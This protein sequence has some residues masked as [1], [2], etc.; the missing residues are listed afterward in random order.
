MDS[1][2]RD[3]LIRNFKVLRQR[4]QTNKAFFKAR[5]YDKVI[6][7]LEEGVSN[8]DDIKGLG[9]SLRQKADEIMDKGFL[10]STKDAIQDTKKTDTIEE[11][12]KIMSIGNVKAQ[13][14]VNEHGIDSVESLRAK[15]AQEPSLLNDKQKMGLKY[16]DDF[17]K[18]IP[19]AEMDKH[20]DLLYDAIAEFT[21]LQ[22]TIT[23]SYRRG[24]ESSGDIDILITHPDDD[25]SLFT[26]LISAL[27]DRKYLVDDFAYGKE[28][29]MGVAKL[30]RHKTYRRID[31]MY[32]PHA[33]YPFALLYFTGSQEFNIEM[34]NHCLEM[35]YS[36]SEHGMKYMTGEE[37]GK[38]IPNV[39]QT[40]NDIFDFL[41][42]DYVEPQDRKKGAIHTKCS[43]CP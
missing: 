4:E 35:G 21:D 41:E 15:V 5:A 26:K 12:M 20:R 40:E 18:R 1:H 10:D 23:G 39:F 7:Q 24:V 27:K 25:K 33:M 31:V 6:K 38:F 30:P 9:A 2:T 14:L 42:V 8:L 34:R 16:H 36:L 28:K 3:L 32:I 29:Y 19:R 13:A 37:K 22:G 11:L 17:L 43:E